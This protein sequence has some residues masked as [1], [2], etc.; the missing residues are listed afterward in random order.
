MYDY[1]DLG[2]IFDGRHTL[3]DFGL[4]WIPDAPLVEAASQRNE[5]EVS[6][7]EETVVYDGDMRKPFKLSG[8]LYPEH[9]LSGVREAGELFRRVV[10]WLKKRRSELVLDYDPGVFYMAQVDDSM[11]FTDK[12]WMEG[13]INVTFICQPGARDRAI[14][15]T[16]GEMDSA[17]ADFALILRGERAADVTVNVTNAGADAITG[18]TVTLAGKQWV[19]EDM[20]LETGETAVIKCVPPVDAYKQSGDTVTSLLACV[21]K[22]ETLKAVPGANIV[23]VEAECEGTVEASVEILAR[24]TY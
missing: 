16:R 15:T 14:C 10:R 19:L 20:E 9:D 5:Y 4:I 22:A 8:N 24:P 3:R 21:S 23:T 18:L 1:K 11:S 17:Q 7:C 2:F 12:N 6:G 13:G